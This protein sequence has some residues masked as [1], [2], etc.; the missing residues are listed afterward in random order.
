MLS[1][2]SWE[3]RLNGDEELKYVQ[4]GFCKT[5]LQSIEMKQQERTMK[6]S[7]LPSGLGDMTFET[8]KPSM[9]ILPVITAA[10]EIVSGKTY[11][12]LYIYG[13]PG[14]GKTHLAVAMLR[15]FMLAGRAGIYVTTVELMEKFKSLSSEKKNF[16]LMDLIQNSPFLIL[17]DLGTEKPSDWVLERLFLILD[18]RSKTARSR[19]NPDGV[20]TV[21]TSNYSL[22]ELIPRLAL[23]GE[24]VSG[25]RIVSRI[26]GMCLPAKMR[27]IDW[28]VARNV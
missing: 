19:E 25:T 9:E 21:I 6:S 20:I 28:R 27:G 11:P 16:E 12:G 8:I 13:E 2:L 3:T 7:K 4:R 10:K 1:F 18:H 23:Q 14:R 5:K 22:E 26:R 24:P 17:D 15:S